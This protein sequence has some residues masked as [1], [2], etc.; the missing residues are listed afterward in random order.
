VTVHTHDPRGFDAGELLWRTH[1]AL[2]A[3]DLG[4]R[5]FFEGFSRVA[6][7]E[8]RAPG[9]PALVHVVQGS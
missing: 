8:A 2:A 7:A 6:T 5:V 9:H 4:Q 1:E 3:F